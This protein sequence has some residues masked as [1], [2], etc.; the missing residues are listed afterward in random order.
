MNPNDI[1]TCWGGSNDYVYKFISEVQNNMDA[2]MNGKL[3]NKKVYDYVLER[4]HIRIL[5]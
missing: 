3:D 4:H 1:L 5:I 2:T